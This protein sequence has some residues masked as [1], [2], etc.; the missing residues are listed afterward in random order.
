MNE[1][2]RAQQRGRERLTAQN[3]KDQPE[4]E[5]TD[6]QNGDNSRS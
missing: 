5:Q 4:S 1:I 3:P 6:D 2:Y